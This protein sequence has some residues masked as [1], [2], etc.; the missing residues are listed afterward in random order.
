MQNLGWI[1]SSLP[2]TPHSAAAAAMSP[3]ENASG[4]NMKE[5][6]ITS[7]HQAHVVVKANRRVAALF[8][9]FELQDEPV[10]L[11]PD[12]TGSSKYNRIPNMPYA[13]A[14][15]ANN[16]LGDGC[17][18]TRAQIGIAIHNKSQELRSALVQYNHT[19]AQGILVI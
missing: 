8:L 14:D 19:L 7:D 10:C 18:P 15:L 12:S 1:I 9:K 11:D 5:L 16:L 3:K 17:D 13:H 4:S 6:Q 2:A